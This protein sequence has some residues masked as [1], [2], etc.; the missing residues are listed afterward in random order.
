MESC[1]RAA[2][3]L[4]LPAVLA[5]GACDDDDDPIGPGGGAIEVIVATSGSALDPD[6]YMLALDGGQGQAVAVDDTVNFADLAVGDH[7][8][9]LTGL[10]ASCGVSGS[11]PRTVTVVAGLTA[12][13]TFDVACVVPLSNQIVASRQGF[14]LYV[15]DADGSNVVPLG[16]GW[17]PDVSPDGTRIAFFANVD[18]HVMN[19]DGTGVTQLTTDA[20]VDSHPAWSPDGTQIVFA[21]NRDG[22]YEVYRMNADGSGQTRLTDDPVADTYPAWS[23]DGSKI[24]FTSGVHVFLMNP[25]GSGVEN[26]TESLGGG[27]RP[28][29]SPDG[30]QIAFRSG[31]LGQDIYIMNSDGS[32]LNQVTDDP[33][34]DF[35]PTWAPDGSKIAFASDRDGNFE[36]YTINV[37]GSGVTRLTD[38]PADDR[39]PVWSP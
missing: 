37:D 10:A 38:D 32:G 39:A 19:A 20:A 31:Q 3:V 33:A 9:E 17:E 2:L 11:N 5:M 28:A 23:P 18:T 36:I 6:G 34:E 22:N 26:L 29:W 35:E 21:S 25:D 14:G 30:T 24:A 8:V 12:S 15:M 4:V 27:E 13:T 1:S 7:V 16:H